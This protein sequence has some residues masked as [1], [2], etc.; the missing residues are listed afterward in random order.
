MCWLDNSSTH[1]QHYVFQGMPY[2]VKEKVGLHKN[3]ISKN[4]INESTTPSKHQVQHGVGYGY[5][6]PQYWIILG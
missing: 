2:A 5:K 1:D 4:Q 6:F 3:R